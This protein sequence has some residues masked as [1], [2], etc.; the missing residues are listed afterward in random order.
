MLTQGMLSFR[1]GMLTAESEECYYVWIPHIHG[2]SLHEWLS[3]THTLYD[4]YVPF[5]KE[6]P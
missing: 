5:H 3:H 2:N 1:A 6:G 4:E